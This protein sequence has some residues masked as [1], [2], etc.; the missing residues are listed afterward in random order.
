MERL[1]CLVAQCASLLRWT[2]QIASFFWPSNKFG[3]NELSLA[4]S[5]PATSRFILD[6]SNC[7]SSSSWHDFTFCFLI[8]CRQVRSSKQRSI[9]DEE[10][11]VYRTNCFEKTKKKHEIYVVYL[12]ASQHNVLLAQT[13]E[14][15]HFAPSIW[16]GRADRFSNLHT[17]EIALSIWQPMPG[18]QQMLGPKHYLKR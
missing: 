1:Q 5:T 14:V 4:P 6:N 8:C 18:P 17:F 12:P 16:H 13:P 2:Y 15:P 9:Q 11:G 7:S 10:S 3:K